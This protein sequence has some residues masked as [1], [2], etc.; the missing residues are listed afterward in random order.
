ML[1]LQYFVFPTFAAPLLTKFPLR[2]IFWC[3]NVRRGSDTYKYIY[4]FYTLLDFPDVCPLL[5]KQYIQ[6]GTNTIHVIQF[7][8]GL[9]PHTWHG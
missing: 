3:H 9:S 7:L 1:K 6:V 5:P 4:F 8:D 2:A